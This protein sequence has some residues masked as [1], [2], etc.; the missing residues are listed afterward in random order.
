MASVGENGSAASS[1]TLSLKG[2]ANELKAEDSLLG[3]PRSSVLTPSS[4]TTPQV[5]LLGPDSSPSTSL[6]PPIDAN[7]ISAA[8]ATSALAA[9]PR[10][11][12]L[13]STFH[14][15]SSAAGLRSALA[16]PDALL[17]PSAFHNGTASL[18]GSGPTTPLEQP[19]AS[20]LLPPSSAAATQHRLR[21]GS[22]TLP[23]SS[24]SSA[25]GP[26]VFSSADWT[27]RT[28]RSGSDPTTRLS[29][30]ASDP[31]S[32]DESSY[33]DDSHVRTLDYL[34]LAEETSSSGGGTNESLLTSAPLHATGVNARSNSLSGSLAP[35]MQRLGSTGSIQPAPSALGDFA[36]HQRLR[37]HTVASAFPPRFNADALS[38]FHS[39]HPSASYPSSAAGHS[40][41]AARDDPFNSSPPQP[42]HLPSHPLHR[43]SSSSDHTR[44]LYATAASLSDATTPPAQAEASVPAPAPPLVSLLPPQ[45]P[46]SSSAAADHPN[47]GRSATIGIIDDS[48]GEM[49]PRRRAGTTAGIP[50]RHLG[51]GATS[52]GEGPVAAMA[53][54]MGRLSISEDPSQGGSGWGTSEGAVSLSPPVQ[55]PTRS[56]W[57]GNLDPKTTPAELQDVFAPYGAIESLR[58]IPEKECGFVNF[59]SVADAMRAK[60]DV[61]NRLGGQLT[62]TSGLVRIGYGKAES[63][64]A[65]TA[66]G[67]VHP[68]STAGPAPVSAAEMNL[69]TQPTRALW[70]G[71]I[72]PTT[73]PNHLLAVFSSFGPIESARVLTHKSCGFVNFERLD[74]AVAARKSLNNREI[75]GAEVGP[76]RIG[77][78]KVPTKVSNAPFANQVNGDGTPATAAANGIG[79]YPHVYNAL[80][81]ISGVSNIPVERQLADGQMQDYRSNMVLGLVGN[82]HYATAHAFQQPSP[83]HGQPVETHKG[84]INEMQL[85]MRELSQGDP[86]LEEHVAAVGEERPPIMYYTSIPLAVLNDPRF[87]RRYSNND[88]PR[89]REIRKRLESELPM[90]EVDEIAHD[91]M[92]EIVPLASDYLGNTLVQKLFEQTSTPV[93]KAM[94]ERIAPHLAPIGT[95]K[96]GTWA[97][98]KV[99]QC[100]QDEDEYALI[101]QSLT[102]YTPP[103]LLNDFGNYVVQGALRFGSPYADFV[104]DAMVDRIWEIGSGRFGARST[105]Q[106]LENPESPRLHVKRVAASIVLNAIPLATSSNGALLIT[107]FLE[108][109]DLP[110]R[111][112]L[113]APRF[114]PHLS[115]LCTHKLASQ[116]IMRV[117]NQHEDDEAQRIM[118]DALLDPNAKVLEDILGDQM[119]GTACIQKVTSS[120]HLTVERRQYLFDRI[121]EAIASLK[122]EAVPAYRK[123]IEEVGGTYLGPPAGNTPPYT[124]GPLPH[125]GG[126]GP[127]R[128]PTHGFGGPPHSHAPSR[129]VPSGHQQFVTPQVP[130][131][132]APGYGTAS[133][134]PSAYSGAAPYPL[135]PP[136]PF[137]GGPAPSSQFGSPFSPPFGHTSPPSS[138]APSASSPAVSPMMAHPGLP[139][140]PGL[141]PGSAYPSISSPDPFQALRVASSDFNPAF[142]PLASPPP[143]FYPMGS[144]GTF[145]AQQEAPGGPFDA[146]KPGN[147]ESSV[148][149]ASPRRRY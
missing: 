52:P 69:Q 4:S 72:P 46:S 65:P 140:S 148:P 85:L 97:V 1:P 134:Y 13:P 41:A 115:H 100:A 135:Y 128:S 14:L 57:V 124:P 45:P 79:S 31:R 144:F 116:S 60:E 119:H 121:K 7:G 88:A 93:R 143:P 98:Q 27:T 86:D 139:F 108:S 114:A 10:A 111:Y 81:Q 23:P 64:P 122:V 66:P 149:P 19:F 146:N 30:L 132:Q 49:I 18:P 90:D 138:H 103:L 9:R 29:T 77:F 101:Q 120:T 58:L 12:T 56:L 63:T 109:S 24:L 80:S 110:N 20:A 133:P 6:F 62:K 44:L 68:R 106:T 53:S 25:F 141:P 126:R 104:F 42:Y 54:R 55:Q 112:S 94:L 40:P 61:L 16:A 92:D 3:P 137:Y 75:L 118:V 125:H 50:P 5:S 36:A 76:V 8:S 15:R 59:V 107:W 37:S 43:P 99:I 28:D 21:S 105:R 48:K 117:I 147:G 87:A 51:I 33:G 95:H 89:L 70:I 102:P 130:Y 38:L 74:D 39:P 96:N 67:L 91:L 11:G 71:S 113:L 78:A 145:A 73:T 26:G 35:P 131:P 129:R 22:L 123:L 34:G 2:R 84:S 142:S 17:A 47:R 127:A 82:S 32:P 136:P 83:P